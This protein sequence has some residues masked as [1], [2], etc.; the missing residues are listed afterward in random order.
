MSAG[1][2]RRDHED[3]DQ[4]RGRRGDG[5]GSKDDGEYGSRIELGF[6]ADVPKLG[7]ERDRNGEPGEYQRRG[8]GERLKE[9][10]LCSGSPLDQQNPGAKR[11]GAG[12]H[13]EQGRDNKGRGQGGGRVEH[14]ACQRRSGAGLKLHSVRCRPFQSRG[15]PSVHPLRAT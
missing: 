4:Q 1:Q 9:C 10:K 8:A 3:W 12:R 6:R 2:H 5:T 11:R 13:N 15:R 7:L 14:V